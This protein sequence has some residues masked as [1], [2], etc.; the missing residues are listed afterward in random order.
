MTFFFFFFSSLFC[1]IFLCCLLFLRVFL[2]F[3]LRRLRS[4]Q[5]PAHR[6]TLR[7]RNNLHLSV[8]NYSIHILKTDKRCDVAPHTLPPLSSSFLL[9]LFPPFACLSADTEATASLLAVNRSAS[10][11][12]RGRTGR[13]FLIWIYLGN[14]SRQSLTCFHRLASLLLLHLPSNPPLCQFGHFPPLVLFLP[15]TVE[16]LIHR[17]TC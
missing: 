2:G 5:D 12:A 11:R 6:H 3:D 10:E 15:G 14:S 9:L 13:G 4:P 8:T 7:Q 1:F 17:N 16:A